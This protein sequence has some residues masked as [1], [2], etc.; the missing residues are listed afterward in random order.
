LP[1]HKVTELRTTSQE[2]KTKTGLPK[3]LNLKTHLILIFLISGIYSRLTIEIDF[4]RMF[5]YYMVSIYIPCLMLVIMSWLT[6]FLNRNAFNMRAVLCGIIFL[7]MIF[8]LNM[9][10]QNIPKTSYTKSVDCYTGICMTFLF[11]AIIGRFLKNIFINYKVNF[12]FRICF[13]LQL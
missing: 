13:R 2:I 1:L 12:Y 8:G 11:V 6:F 5:N 10:Q 4:Q 9:I 7:A 3:I